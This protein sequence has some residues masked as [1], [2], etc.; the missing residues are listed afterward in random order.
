MFHKILYLVLILG[1]LPDLQSSHAPYANYPNTFSSRKITTQFNESHSYDVCT[2][3]SLSNSNSCFMNASRL[4]C[5]KSMTYECK[6]RMA[7]EYEIKIIEIYCLLTAI[8]ILTIILNLSMYY[9][10][11]L[12]MREN[13]LTYLE[14]VV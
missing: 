3:P 12:E 7:N 2:E 9:Y 8:I 6:M 14:Y 4:S 5:N 11:K 10:C 13:S 1:N